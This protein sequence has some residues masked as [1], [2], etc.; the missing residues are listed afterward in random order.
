MFLPVIVVESGHSIEAT[1]FIGWI[2]RVKIAWRVLCS[3]LLQ[4]KFF[5]A[6]QSGYLVTCLKPPEC[7]QRIVQSCLNDQLRKPKKESEAIQGS[8]WEIGTLSKMKRPSW[9]SG[10]SSENA[11]SSLCSTI[12][13][14]EFFVAYDGRH[15][16]NSSRREVSEVN[17]KF[18]ATWL[19]QWKKNNSENK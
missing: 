14:S 2:T 17:V 10:I 5:P 19:K 16:S 8:C 3:L 15:L 11:S 9:T 7:C 18:L 4:R 12:F 13:T 6:F 1:N